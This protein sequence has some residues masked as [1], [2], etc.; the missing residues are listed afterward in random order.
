MLVPGAPGLGNA[1]NPFATRTRAKDNRGQSMSLFGNMYAEVDFLRHFTVRSSIGGQLSSGN[2]FFFVNRTYENAENNSG[3]TYTEGF[4]RFRT[5]TLTNQLTYKNVFRNLHDVTAVIGT[6]AI[7]E[8][9]RSIEGRRGGYFL[10]D[11]DFRSLNNGSSGQVANGG[12]FTP[13]ALYS[14][15]GKVDYTFNDKYLA[16]VTVRRD[17]SSR[18]GPENRYGV[19]PAF[20]VAW[21]V[22]EESFMDGINWLSDLKIRAS[23]GIMRPLQNK[24]L[25]F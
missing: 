14:L 24:R 2:F 12:P 13:A 1:S 17:G 11:P 18:F 20:S 6:E 25:N 22:S 9:G 7:E 15:F 16:S 21:R 19:F 4:N 5:W 8:F 3:N 10:E 23:Y